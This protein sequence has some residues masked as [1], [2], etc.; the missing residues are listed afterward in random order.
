[1]S[2]SDKEEEEDEE[3]ESK[4]F[5]IVFFLVAAVVDFFLS[6]AIYREKKAAFKKSLLIISI[7]LNLGLLFYF[8][9]FQSVRNFE[10]SKGTKSHGSETSHLRERHRGDSYCMHYRIK[11]DPLQY[12]VKIARYLD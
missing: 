2:S 6:N 9:Y 12:A 11:M 3:E 4:I 5:L 1:M 10:S 7:I 8:K